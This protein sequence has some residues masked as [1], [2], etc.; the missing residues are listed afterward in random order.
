MVQ[1]IP[2]RH[3]GDEFTYE[4]KHYLYE[5]GKLYILGQCDVDGKF[6]GNY[7]IEDDIC[8]NQYIP[9]QGTRNYDGF[10]KIKPRKMPPPS[11]KLF[12]M[13]TDD[14]T[15]GTASPDINQIL[16][17]DEAVKRMIKS[18]KLYKPH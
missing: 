2:I 12:Y 18:V 14:T 15:T 6:T 5:D 7:W 8:W 10:S 13:T 17:D 1:D 4:G 3:H 9:T 11:G 16:S